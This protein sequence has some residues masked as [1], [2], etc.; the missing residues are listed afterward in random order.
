MVTEPKDPVSPPA[1]AEADAAAPEPEGDPPEPAQKIIK[2]YSN[3]KLYDTDRSKYVTLDE[4]AEMIRRGDDVKIIDN[5]TKGDLTSA[6][7]AQIIFESEKKQSRMP[8]GML[9]NLI[10]TGGDALQDFI[11]KSVKTPVENV[12]DTA[13]KGV[14]E[15]KQSAAQLAE[16]ATR[17]VTDLTVSARKVF[18]RDETD[19]MA[20][21]VEAAMRR[22]E[23]A[24]DEL[25]KRLEG[26]IREA[27]E[28]GVPVV[29]RLIVEIERRIAEL[30]TMLGKLRQAAQDA[31]GSEGSATAAPEAGD[32][33]AKSDDDAEPTN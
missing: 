31:E 18:T 25:T 9:R 19:A 27:A 16:V 17:S 24:F 21:Q 22:Y 23:G 26:Q 15:F 6:T 33:G 1:V 32:D 3:R 5:R 11:D 30:H 28:D 29:E 7:L 8:L 10:Q 12:R 13:Q 2:R 14:E 20:E 4:I